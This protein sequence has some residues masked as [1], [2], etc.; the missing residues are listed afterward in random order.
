MTLKA[1]EKRYV[2]NTLDTLNKSVLNYFYFS[3]TGS[4]DA[5]G[6]ITS[7][8]NY[9]KLSDYC[10]CYL[11][12]DCKSL[13]KAPLMLETELA[14]ECY[15]GMFKGSGITEMP[16]LPAYDNIPEYAFLEAFSKCESLTILKKITANSVDYEGL[17]STFSYCTGLTNIPEDLLDIPEIG[18]NGFS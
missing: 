16:D 3:M 12:K 7:M 5:D 10:F 9:A 14:K 17:G 18:E 15:R 11:F 8:I 4:F 1:G 6:M 2:R 13:K